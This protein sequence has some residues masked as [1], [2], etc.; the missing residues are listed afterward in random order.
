MVGANFHPSCDYQMFEKNSNQV[1]LK[2][3]LNVLNKYETSKA[4]FFQNQN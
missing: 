1:F 3:Q 2:S 4:S